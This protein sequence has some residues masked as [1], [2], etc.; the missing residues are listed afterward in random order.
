MDS[1]PSTS[2]V[3]HFSRLLTILQTASK[4]MAARFTSSSPVRQSMDL[5]TA[6]CES[7][8]VKT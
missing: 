5:A 8:S 4:Q 6:Q 7:T 3:R 1:L 2:T